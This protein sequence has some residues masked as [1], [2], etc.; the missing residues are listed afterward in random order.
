MR[1]FL[2]S[3][4]LALC[5]LS[6]AGFATTYDFLTVTGNGQ[7]GN[8]ANS[9]FHSQNGNGTINVTHFFPNPAGVGQFDNIN[10]AINSSYPGLFSS[11]PVDGHLAMTV[12]NY[13]SVVTFHMQNFAIDTQNTLFGIWNITD[14]VS[15]PGGPGGS[16]QPTY[17]I[18]LLDSVNGVT[19]PS[20]MLTYG[21]D[22]NASDVQGRHHLD[23]NPSTGELS[24]TF[25]INGGNGVHTDAT[26]LYNIPTTTLEIRVYAD[27]PPLNSIGDGVGYYFTEAHVP[28]P[29]TI[30]VFSLV[31]AQV[32]RRNR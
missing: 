21:N 17:R 29:A 13:Q 10:T 4:S 27:L 19:T 20:M 24:P 12:Y 18:E 26:F 32:L 11:A 14:E 9:V 15:W 31:I 25:P 16:S 3:I 22:Q 28:E 6:S 5:A 2:A 1:T 30:A 7:S 23:F 8:A